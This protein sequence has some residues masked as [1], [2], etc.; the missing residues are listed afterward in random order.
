MFTVIVCSFA[1]IVV[2]TM[3]IPIAILEIVGGAIINRNPKKILWFFAR[4]SF[5]RAVLI[6]DKIPTN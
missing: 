4:K 1:C 5:N 6:L 3:E 2:G